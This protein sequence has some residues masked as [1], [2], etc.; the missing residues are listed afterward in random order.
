MDSENNTNQTVCESA[1]M[2]TIMKDNTAVLVLELLERTS[3][4]AAAFRPVCPYITA[5]IA[6]ESRYL[7]TYDHFPSEEGMGV[8]EVVMEDF[9]NY[10][11]TLT[12][13]ETET[14]EPTWWVYS[15]VIYTMMARLPPDAAY[16]PI[17]HYCQKSLANQLWW[18]LGPDFRADQKYEVS[19][20]SAKVP[21]F[22][23][24]PYLTKE[25]VQNVYGKVLSV[26]AANYKRDNV[27]EI[28]V[29]NLTY[30]QH[31]HLLNIAFSFHRGDFPLADRN[32]YRY[33]AQEFVQ[34]LL[35]LET[36]VARNTFKT[37]EYYEHM[38]QLLEP[39]VLDLAEA[40]RPMS[41]VFADT[42]VTLAY[43]LFQ[44]LRPDKDKE[45]DPQVL[46]YPPRTLYLPPLWQITQI[47]RFLHNF[48]FTAPSSL[49]AQ[50]S[51]PVDDEL[52]YTPITVPFLAG[53]RAQSGPQGR[54]T[55]KSKVT[56]PGSHRKHKKTKSERVSPLRACPPRTFADELREATRELATSVA[57]AVQTTLA[58]HQAG[59][60]RAPAAA[61][62]T[63]VSSPAPPPA[64]QEQHNTTPTVVVTPHAPPTSPAAVS[65]PA[66]LPGSQVPSAT[67]PSGIEDL[68]YPPSHSPQ[69]QRSRYGTGTQPRQVRQATAPISTLPPGQVNGGFLRS[70]LTSPGTV[71]RRWR[72]RHIYLDRQRNTYFELYVTY[73]A[74][75]GFVP[76]ATFSLPQ[77]WPF[78]PGDHHIPG[79]IPQHEIVCITSHHH[80]SRESPLPESHLS[81][82]RH[83][84]QL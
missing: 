24:A 70:Y 3:R 54:A 6:L 1:V 11:K 71:P 16:R 57:T 15:G 66:P 29:D 27:S 80:V 2:A 75:S 21:T 34:E 19:L 26:W 48:A 20:S 82:L 36:R 14:P 22:A 25:H 39:L 12:G 9:E 52:M 67:G 51:L 64:H 42:L 13:P 53:K 41:L 7:L 63:V 46:N 56:S 79:D 72:V 81:Q 68:F 35:N 50:Y 45:W 84:R 23:H 37:K 18:S 31:P 83:L 69:R 32:Q 74:E 58:A 61:P 77:T 60:A 44:D 40:I 76:T 55:L 10:F 30:L 5:A 49:Q 62:Q 47:K 8:K 59:T 73:D 38:Q 28:S 78:P 43:G 17:V 65:S 4:V 33:K